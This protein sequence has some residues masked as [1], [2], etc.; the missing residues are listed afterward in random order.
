MI[1]AVPILIQCPHCNLK[2]VKRSILSGNTFGAQYW[3]DGKM[4]APMFPEYPKVVVCKNCQDHFWISDMNKGDRFKE[5]KYR[6]KGVYELEFPTIEEYIQL[7]DENASL[8]VILLYDFKKV[9]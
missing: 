7:L 4:D 6:K 3:S 1:P 8:K 2:Y 5:K 9:L